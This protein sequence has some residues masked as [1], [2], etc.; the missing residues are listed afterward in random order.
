MVSLSSSV[1]PIPGQSAAGSSSTRLG[2]AARFPGQSG[3]DEPS[4]AVD[5]FD[6][7]GDDGASTRAELVARVRAE[8]K[9]GTYD[10]DEKFAVAVRRAI[11]SVDVTA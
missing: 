7:S 6:P 3:S 4:R 11:N 1:N 10:T 9:A 2:P 5:R 8:L